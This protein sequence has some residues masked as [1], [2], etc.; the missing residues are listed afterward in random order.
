MEVAFGMERE[1]ISRRDFVFR[2]LLLIAMLTVGSVLVIDELTHRESSLTNENWI[3]EKP[4][5]RYESGSSC[6]LYYPRE[7]S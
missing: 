4:L 6:P 5:V 7:D 3:P 2:I 1:K